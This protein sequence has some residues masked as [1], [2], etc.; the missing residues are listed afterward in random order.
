MLLGI[1]GFFSAASFVVAALTEVQ[2]EPAVT[3]VIVLMFFMAA[4]YFA[5]RAWRQI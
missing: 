2:G 1:L 4:T 5:H 3:E